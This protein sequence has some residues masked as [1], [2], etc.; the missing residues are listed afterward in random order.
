MQFTKYITLLCVLISC[1]ACELFEES[2]FPRKVQFPKEGGAKNI[3]GDWNLRFCCVEDN[4]YNEV[5][6]ADE[7]C[8]KYKYGWLE[9]VIEP[10]P[11]KLLTL[12]VQPNTTDRPRTLRLMISDGSPP[13]DEIYIYQE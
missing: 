8:F 13:S 9:V 2:G 10:I 4:E 3:T 5:V 11:T 1:S 6:H 12:I 7:R